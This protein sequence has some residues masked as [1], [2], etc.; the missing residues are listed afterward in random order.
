MPSKHPPTGFIPLKLTSA[1]RELCGP[2][3]QHGED[4][5]YVI[6]LYVQKKHGNMRG[7]VHGGMIATLADTALGF[8]ISSA[9]RTKGLVTTSLSV[10]YSGNAE[11]GD[12]IE[13]RVD[14]QRL[15]RR[16]CF[17]NCDIWRGADRI[18][19]ASGAFLVVE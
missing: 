12:W 10:T 3:Y 1:F 7:L 4:G 17:A 14:I 13:A 11:V 15:G 9:T 19:H 2:L 16:V 18:A 5:T 8:G 6:G